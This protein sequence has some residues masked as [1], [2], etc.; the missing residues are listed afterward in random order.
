MNY[1]EMPPD[2]RVWIYQSTRGLS[3]KEIEEINIKGQ[4]F[5]EQ[6]T[7]HGKLLKASF[8]IFYDRFLI[9]FVDEKQAI[10]SGCSIDKSVNF[11]KEIEKKFNLNLF[12][13]MAV[14]YKKGNEIISCRLNEFEKLLQKGIVNENTIVFNNLVQSKAEFDKSWEVPVKE[15][16]HKRYHTAEK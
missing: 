6:W 12:D 7:A 15:S 16:W 13:R 2:S 9:F 5:I 3:Q 4:D 10:A 11:V 8:E 14:A 1:K